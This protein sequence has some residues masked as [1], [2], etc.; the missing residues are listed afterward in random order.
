MKTTDRRFTAAFLIVAIGAGV[1]FAA[2]EWAVHDMNRPTPPV[3]QPG[4][5]SFASV[6]S[7]AIVLFDGSD[8]SKWTGKD[9][10]ARWE[11]SQGAAKANK[12]GSIQTRQ[13]FGDCQLH[14]EFRT[15]DDPKTLKKKSQGRGNSGVFF[16][17]KYELQVLDSY[18]NRTYAD[19][20]AAAVYGQYPPL[21]NASLPPG[22]WQAY[23]VVFRRPHFD[24]SGQ[25]VTPAIITAFHNGVL[26]QDHV[27][28]TGATVHK[29]RA[30]YTPH[31]DA[32]PLMLQD[33]GDPVRFRNIWI[34]PLE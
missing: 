12:T 19:G 29:K 7:D 5:S 1:S 17:G 15:P 10:R 27:E 22:H 21:V 28:L 11:V 14:I 8:L 16:M 4:D 25:V 30:K 18:Y 24:S 13:A 20:Q 32:L 33:H 23:D 34:R 2:T 3:I 26:V 31:A 9:G 6:P